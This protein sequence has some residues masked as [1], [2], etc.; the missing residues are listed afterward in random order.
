MGW[1]APILL[2][3]DPPYKVG[4]KR[5]GEDEDSEERKKTV[6]SLSTDDSGEKKNWG[7][8]KQHKTM[9]ALLVRHIS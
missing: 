5:A 4:K 1:T 2:Y 7:R 6:I 8:A 3:L 9:W